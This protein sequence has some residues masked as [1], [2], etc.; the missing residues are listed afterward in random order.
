MHGKG[1]ALLFDDDKL[2]VFCSATLL[3]CLF[4]TCLLF[5]R[6]MPDRIRAL[7]CTSY[8]VAMGL[9]QKVRYFVRVVLHTKTVFA[10]LLFKED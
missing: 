5:V 6:R 8:G 2:L 3:V 7:S 9:L 10:G 1:L 4:A